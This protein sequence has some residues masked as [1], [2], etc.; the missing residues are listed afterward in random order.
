VDCCFWVDSFDLLV[1]HFGH[2]DLVVVGIPWFGFL[3]FSHVR[4][5]L[6]FFVAMLSA[7]NG[8]RFVCQ[9]CKA[10]RLKQSF[11]GASPKI[12]SRIKKE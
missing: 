2:L 6:I 9:C 3:N 4:F 10:P 11:P 12:F 8:P 7:A 5:F 1:A